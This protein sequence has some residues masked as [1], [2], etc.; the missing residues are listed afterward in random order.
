MPAVAYSVLAER[1]IS[2]FIQDRIGPNRVGPGGLWQPLADGV[3]AFLKEDF[4][5]RRTFA[6]PISGWRR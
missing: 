4:T 6:K 3:K 1:K 2:A 5:S